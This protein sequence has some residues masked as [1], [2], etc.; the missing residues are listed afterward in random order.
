MST[1]PN[2]GPSAS[3]DRLTGGAIWWGKQQP[4]TALVPNP[5]RIR[6]S[7][8]VAARSAPPACAGKFEAERV[9]GQ[10]TVTRIE[11]AK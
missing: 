10:F 7:S 11:K 4:F 8:G 2:L 6:P 5:Y 1:R 3:L 9:N